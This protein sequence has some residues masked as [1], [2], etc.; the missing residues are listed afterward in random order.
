M[1]ARLVPGFL[2]GK[3]HRE[4][5]SDR[6]RKRHRRRRGRLN[7]APEIIVPPPGSSLKARL[8]AFFAPR[9]DRWLR[10][11]PLFSAILAPASTLYD[12]PA[13][14]QTWLGESEADQPGLNTELVLSSIELFFSVAANVVLVVRFSSVDHQRARWMTRF[15]T[16]IWILK[17][18]FGPH[19][20][21]YLACCSPR[22]TNRLQSAW[23]TSRSLPLSLTTIDCRR[24]K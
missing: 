24:F 20:T 23:S 8:W 21:P 16:L 12:I 4:P 2:V 10:D 9:V 17:V 11:L 15:S 22:D 19:V 6:R 7:D 14:S 3:G 18:A 13:L 1:L 5:G